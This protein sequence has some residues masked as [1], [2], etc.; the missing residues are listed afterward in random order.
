M[1]NNQC[2]LVVLL[3]TGFTKKRQPK[4]TLLCMVSL[5]FC[6]STGFSSCNLSPLNASGHHKFGRSTDHAKAG[7]EVKDSI[8]AKTIFFIIK[9][10]L[11]FLLLFAVFSIK[12][13]FFFLNLFQYYSKKAQQYLQF[14]LICGLMSQSIFFGRQSN[15]LISHTMQIIVFCFPK[16][17]PGSVLV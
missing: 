15:L 10:F 11:L 2:I 17:I 6:F 4:L 16:S 12:N 14:P 8:I 7:A 9:T 5:Y 13:K 3:C 1:A